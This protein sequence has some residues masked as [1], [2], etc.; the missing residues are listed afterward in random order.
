MIKVTIEGAEVRVNDEALEEYK[1]LKLAGQVE[2]NPLKIFDLI[3]QIVDGGSDKV[4]SIIDPENGNPKIEEYSTFVE[5]IFTAL[6]ENKQTK[7][8]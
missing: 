8:L 1:T 7:N 6:G 4:A 3:D 2:K 5:K